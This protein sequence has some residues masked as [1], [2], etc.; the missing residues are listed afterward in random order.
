MV[1]FMTFKISAVTDS[2][3]LKR[4]HWRS[5]SSSTFSRACWSFLF[6]LIL[7]LLL[8]S[9]ARTR[10]RNTSLQFSLSLRSLLICSG[11]T[12]DGG[13]PRRL[14]TG[15]CCSRMIFGLPRPL[16]V[17]VSIVLSWAASCL[18]P[19]RS[20]ELRDRLQKRLKTASRTILVRSILA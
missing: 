18:G 8:A 3:L 5:V 2:I 4:Q 1:A 6:L 20:L 16:L 19:L 11:T 10:V 17:M 14:G 12:I 7:H 15:V 13:L 9:L